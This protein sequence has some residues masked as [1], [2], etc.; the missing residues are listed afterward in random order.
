MKASISVVIPTHK[1]M[2]R[3]DAA[4]LVYLT[5][6][7][8][9]DAIIEDIEDCHQRSQP[10]LVGTTS[11]ETSEYLSGILDKL[12]IPHQVLNAKQHQKEAEIIVNAGR[13]GTVTIATNMAGRGTDIVLG[14][15][16]EFLAA[17]EAGEEE[18]KKFDEAYAGLKSR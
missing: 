7:D 16:A 12:H 9:F 5:Q 8:K 6:K 3:D 1:D 2:V 11:I 4:D 13:P 14:G 15:N 10:V 18:G 17:D